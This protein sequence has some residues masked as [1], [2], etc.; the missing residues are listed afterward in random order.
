[1]A[2]G[3][4]AYGIHE[5]HELGWIPPVI[6]PVWNT[7]HLLN[8]KEGIGSFLKALFGYNGNPSLVEVMAY[9]VYL[10]TVVTLL[11]RSTAKP[12]AQ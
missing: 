10:V 3:L 8:E 4:L 5:L 7:N 12:V 11:R 1:M 2:A 6:D 9:G